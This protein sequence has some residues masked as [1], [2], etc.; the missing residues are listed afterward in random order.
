METL[1]HF[2]HEHNCRCQELIDQRLEQIRKAVPATRDQAVLESSIVL[3]HQVCKII[4]VLNQGIADLDER[5]GP[6]RK[7]IPTT[8]YSTRRRVPEK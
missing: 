3:T 2:F 5:F 7:R 1:V 4:A 6:W 8:P